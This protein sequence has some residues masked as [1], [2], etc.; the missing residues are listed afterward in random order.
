M[1]LAIEPFNTIMHL[2]AYVDDRILPAVCL[3]V[4]GFDV[5]H[6]QVPEVLW[7]HIA[8]DKLAGGTRSHHFRYNFLEIIEVRVG[9]SDLILPIN[10]II[11]SCFPGHY[12]FHPPLRQGK[13]YQEL[14][15]WI[16]II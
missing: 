7:G 12:Q 11:V 4:P 16:L 9:D 10:G 3:I 13:S 2:E 8:L 6:L 15:G 1:T 14:N 5:L